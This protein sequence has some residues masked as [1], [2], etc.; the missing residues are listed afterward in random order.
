MPGKKLTILVP[1]IILLLLA[2]DFDHFARGD[3]RLELTARTAPVIAILIVQYALLGFG[4]YLYRKNLVG[5]LYWVIVAGAGVALGFLAHF[6]PFSEQTPQVI[7]RAYASPAAGA[8]AVFVLA[9]LMLS[10]AATA[11]HAQYLRAKGWK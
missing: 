4:L 5:P 1:A 8:L 7:F 6:S 9:L 3:F 2:H 11:A 10:L